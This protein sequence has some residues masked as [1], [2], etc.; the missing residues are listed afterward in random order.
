VANAGGVI[1]VA[2]EGPGYSQERVLGRVETIGRTMKEIFVR[3]DAE[4]LPT[5]IVADRMAEE[6]FR[7][8][9]ART[10]AA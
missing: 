9:E 10:I 1:D 7:K 2:S 8:A 3:A 5:S 6:I 4:G